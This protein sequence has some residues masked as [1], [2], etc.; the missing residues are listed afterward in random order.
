LLSAA[1][2]VLK[3][4]KSDA[5]NTLMV[6][7]VKQYTVINCIKSFSQVEEDTYSVLIIFQGCT[8]LIR[9][10]DQSMTDVDMFFSEDILSFR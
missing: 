4:L 5:T 2:M 8:C 7:F 9:K 6:E 10:I 3:P 1:E